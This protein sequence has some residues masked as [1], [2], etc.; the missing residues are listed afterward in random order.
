MKRLYLILVLL[1]SL[2]AYSQNKLETL[3]NYCKEVR[4]A[5][6][7]GNEGGW[8]NDLIQNLER[9]ISGY[10]PS[11]DPTKTEFFFNGVPIKLSYWDDGLKIKGNN[12]PD[13]N[14]PMQFFDPGSVDNYLAWL[15]EDIILNDIPLLRSAPYDYL[16]TNLYL[17]GNSKITL[18]ADCIGETNLLI[19]SNSSDSLKLNIICKDAGT[20]DKITLS[21]QEPLHVFTWNTN[22]ESGFTIS[23]ENLS[24]IPVTVFIAKD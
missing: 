9:T 3:Y 11:K 21:S 18:K 20:D 7:K 5:Y 22:N 4:E 10:Y 14:T 1:F 6:I 12:Q 2:S 8:S 23:I 17:K 15:H 13:T 19:T 16:Y 24:A